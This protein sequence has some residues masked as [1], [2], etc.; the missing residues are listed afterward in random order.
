GYTID[1]SS[2][3]PVPLAN[4]HVNTDGARYVSNRTGLFRILISSNDTIFITAIGYREKIILA[5]NILPQNGD[6]TVRTYL[7][8]IVY[9]LREVNVESNHKRDSI[10]R[11]AAEI[12][13]T[14]PLL[15]NY[16]RVIKRDKGGMMSPL[17]AMYEAWS[18]EGQ[19]M[20]H[21]E[22]FLRYAE[23][24]K[25]IDKRYNRAVVKKVT[26]IEDEDLDDFMMFC[27]IKRTLILNAP[28]Y[29]LYEAIR[30]CGNEFKENKSRERTR[31]R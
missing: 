21:F 2:F 7:R 19:D 18:K 3:A 13:K 14:D 28:D 23:Q 5:K 30:K 17:T 29:D 8:P 4:I 16:D 27:K 6:D 26:E 12:L 24:Q 20:A 1:E 9:K 10:A 15:N 25:E 11:L 31:L 22:E